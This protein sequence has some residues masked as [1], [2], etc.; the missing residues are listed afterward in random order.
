MLEGESKHSSPSPFVS[1]SANN[2]F[3][4]VP[5]GTLDFSL[6]L[7]HKCTD[8]TVINAVNDVP[9]KKEILAI[10]LKFCAKITDTA[11]QYICTNC[12]NLE[13]LDLEGCRRVT[14]HGVAGLVDLSSLRTLRL[15]GLN[16]VSAGVVLSVAA[17]CGELSSLSLSG[18]AIDDKAIIDLSNECKGIQGLELV[19][20]NAVS[21]T[22][23][24]NLAG[25]LNSSLQTLNL[26][27]CSKITDLGVE[28][29]AQQC[30]NLVS[31][32]LYGCIKLSSA[33]IVA[34]KKCTHLRSLN[35]SCTAVDDDGIH[36]LVA[37]GGLENLREIDIYNC[38]KLSDAVIGHLESNC[39]A[40]SLIKR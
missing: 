15:D 25:K 13:T 30:G 8:I 26:S 31:L 3:D 12:P 6:R 16:K 24:L 11:V 22:G 34:L 9:D 32:N 2:P 36:S 19:G 38:Q 23:L 4:E 7:S 40:L 14:D 37:N 1:H 17:Q 21:D 35:L 20:C 18:L 39:A 33:G 29:L 5:V 10:V 27:Y 28:A